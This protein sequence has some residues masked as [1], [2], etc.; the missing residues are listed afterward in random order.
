MHLE[1]LFCTIRHFYFHL[2]FGMIYFFHSSFIAPHYLLKAISSIL[3]II[4]T[5]SAANSMALVLTNSG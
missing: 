5:V 1:H 4:L 2:P 3:K